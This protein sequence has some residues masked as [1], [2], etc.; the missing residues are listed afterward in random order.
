MKTFNITKLI[1]LAACAVVFAS[2]DDDTF[3]VD[4]PLSDPVNINFDASVLSTA[5]PASFTVFANDD[6]NMFSGY[7]VL[8]RND[9]AFRE[10]IPHLSNLSSIDINKALLTITEEDAGLYYAEDVIIT[11]QADGFTAT[12]GIPSY[13]FGEAFNSNQ[14]AEFKEFLNKVIFQLIFVGG[15]I[16]LSVDGKTNAIDGDKLNVHLQLADVVLK[17]KT[18]QKK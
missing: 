8:N 18:L 9:E 2:C 6:L 5:S 1:L 13:Q 10:I 3:I 16:K 12:C 11:A 4:I 15:D 7:I 14:N 17:V